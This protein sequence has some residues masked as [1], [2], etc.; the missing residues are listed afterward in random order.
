MKIT[1]LILFVSLIIIGGV[2]ASVGLAGTMGFGGKP[3]QSSHDIIYYI[4]TFGMV[5]L[6][7]GGFLWIARKL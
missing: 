2:G 4:V 3:F 7:I 6:G 5:I 1:L